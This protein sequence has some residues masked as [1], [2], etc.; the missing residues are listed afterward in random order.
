[1]PTLFSRI[2]S[3]E[4]P[5]YKI[6]EDAD[7][8]AF[9]D[10]NPIVK[11]HTL[12]IPKLEIDH[13]FDLPPE[14][15]EKILHFAQPIAQALKEVFQVARCGLTVMGLEVPHAHMHLLPINS[16][17]DM[18]FANPKLPLS[19]ADFETIRDQIIRHLAR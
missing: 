17:K 10:I 8:L 15:L 5:A 14:L 19:K 11:G 16:E 6:A 12:I 7:F 4:I 1:M 3:G 9:L 2:V 13:F 18:N